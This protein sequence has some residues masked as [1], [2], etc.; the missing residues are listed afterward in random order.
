MDY[1]INIFAFCLP[2]LFLSY[3]AITGYATL[4]LLRTQ[5]NVLQNVLLAPAIGF[6]VNLL[7]IF[8]LNRFGIPV[9][10]FAMPL[11]ISLLVI[12]TTIFCYRKPIFPVKQYL[13]F[14]GLFLL[15]LSVT[16]HP[17]LK[18]GFDWVSYS[19]D[20]MANYAMGA[21]RFLNHGYFDPPSIK[22]LI[23]GHDYT[24]FYWFL[25]VPGMVRSGSELMIAFVTGVT[26]LSP[27]K[28]FMPI[29]LAFHL[30]LISSTAAMVCVG[31]SKRS[32]ALIVCLL[33]CFSALNTLSTLYQLI[34]Q[35]DGLSLL[36]A[37]I[38]LIFQRFS[39][40]KKNNVLLQSILI[41]IVLTTL[42]ITYPEVLP[43]LIVSF[44]LYFTLSLIKGWRTNRSFWA[45][46]AL[47]MLLTI[48]LVNT[49]ML[50]V[51]KFL[52]NQGTGAT[53]HNNLEYVLF[54]YYLIPSGLANLWGIQA[55]SIYPKEPYMSLTILIG[56]LL[57]LITLAAMLR[58]IWLRVSPPAIV[59]LVMC[60]VAILL[61]MRNGDF[62][63]FK[64][65]LYV[66][67]FIL[68]VIAIS[69]YDLPK[70]YYRARVGTVITLIVIGMYSLVFYIA[71]SNAEAPGSFTEVAYGSSTKIN[72]EY[73]Q[74]INTLPKKSLIL[75]NDFNVCLIK[76]QSLLSIDHYYRP[77][78][79]PVIYANFLKHTNISNP[80]LEPSKQ[81]GWHNKLYES[82]ATTTRGD[83]IDDSLQAQQFNLFSSEQPTT[84]FYENTFCDKDC[85]KFV[86]IVLDS[87]RR[88]IIN[89]HYDTSINNNNFIL[90][91]L[92]QIHNQLAFI[93][94]SA[95]RIYFSAG[96]DKSDPMSNDAKARLLITRFSLFN[97]EG[98]PL[99]PGKIMQAVGRYL[100]FKII[101]PDKQIRVSVALTKTLSADG[102]FKLS[103]LDLIGDK[104]FTV[105]TMGRGAAHLFSSP[106]SPQIINNNPY[107]A[108]DM[109]KDGKLFPSRRT[110]LA[111]LYGTH[112]PSD[113]R[114]INVFMRD[115]S[116]ISEDDYQHLAIPTKVEHF[117]KDLTEPNLEFSG[118]YEDGWLSEDAFFVLKQPS[119]KS[120][121][122]IKGMLP[123]IDKGF[124]GSTLTVILDGKKVY[125]QKIKP[126]D[127]TIK[128]PVV[129][130]QA[131]RR[132]VELHF[133]QFQRL[134]GKDTRIIGAQAAFIGFQPSQNPVS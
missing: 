2:L 82:E 60:C 104:R 128:L 17:L 119:Q 36:A 7:P 117:P 92:N 97:I 112:V 75:S 126:G 11:F 54:P 20:D 133:E 127:F 56:A 28:T 72:K 13:P 4:S 129:A 15:A 109:K 116:I 61:F 64:L 131:S 113:R 37:S 86:T 62:G 98:D 23:Q 53:V 35:V 130:A 100:L 58:L 50:A 124:A 22:D 18:F 55:L 40:H 89:S 9:S 66:Q 1:V 85:D 30:M 27:L 77:L 73:A 74:L 46:F 103:N 47:T 76:F 6:C 93:D 57:S 10:N 134:P 39:I 122:V 79:T 114:K 118:I 14:A 67:P 43:F 25:H 32:I 41:A 90:K 111:R 125:S 120:E 83:A 110:G 96:F 80:Y 38:T 91:P 59:T 42:L 65:A 51:V 49:H 99:F 108:I 48:A 105:P 26:H 31:K 24:Q 63:L 81:P 121:L 3:L 44:A 19:N 34:A 12:S 107:F 132:R 16:G 102:V 69:L 123:A 78:I 106:L 88:T 45:C 5:R 95:G 52:T 29:I 70:K 33:L 21:L 68:S 8:W 87:S 101:N 84:E 115:I 71:R 94:S